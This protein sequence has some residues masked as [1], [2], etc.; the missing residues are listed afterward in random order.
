MARGDSSGLY[1]IPYTTPYY[2]LL[3]LGKLTIHT[4]TG[5]FAVKTGSRQRKH[6]GWVGFYNSGRVARGVAEQH[7]L[8]HNQPHRVLLGV[9]D[10]A[11]SREMTPEERYE[12]TLGFNNMS[13]VDFYSLCRSRLGIRHPERIPRDFR[14][15]WLTTVW[16]SPPVLVIPMHF[17]HFYRPE[18]LRRFKQPV[19]FNYPAGPV[20]GTTVPLTPMV[21][22]AL[23]EVG[24]EL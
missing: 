3:L 22:K 9:G 7:G 23:A 21:R 6:R 20:Q 8:D 11:D 13:E 4:A 1:V 5:D 24:V 18:S 16:P 10:L 19:P 12:L 15:D 17:G 2:E 14:Y